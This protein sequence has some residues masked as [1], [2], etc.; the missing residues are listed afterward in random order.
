MLDHASWPL[1]NALSSASLTYPSPPKPSAASA[2]TG[3]TWSA[4]H[5]ASLAKLCITG[6][7]PGDAPLLSHLSNLRTLTELH[8]AAPAW[9]AGHS[10]GLQAGLGPLSRLQ[11]L[12]LRACQPDSDTAN[13]PGDLHDLEPMGFYP[14]RAPLSLVLPSSQHPA[15][16]R[17]IL[18]SFI[19]GFN[20]T[21]VLGAVDDLSVRACEVSSLA[22]LYA[23]PPS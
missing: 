1:C 16:S 4:L 23:C 11:Q 19:L 6:L 13:D 5:A 22:A 12:S 18:D 10:A 9:N 2:L 17:V 21:L 7:P 3:I 8:V 14:Y 15:L 20:G